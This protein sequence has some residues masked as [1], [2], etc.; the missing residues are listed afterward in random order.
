MAVSAMATMASCRPLG[1]ELHGDELQRAEY[2]DAG[3][4]DQPVQ[5]GVAGVAGHGVGGSGDLDGIGD[6]QGK[7]MISPKSAEV[8]GGAS[9]GRRTPA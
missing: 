3:V 2:A 9:V 4:V 7:G 8:G 1:R 5:S 6:V